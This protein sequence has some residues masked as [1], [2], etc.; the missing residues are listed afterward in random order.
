LPKLIKPDFILTSPKSEDDFER[1]Y[2]FRWEQ[3]RKPLNLPLGSERDPLDERSFNCMALNCENL[4]IGVGSIQSADNNT[5]RIRYMAVM[6]QLRG[7]GI[8]SEIVK[9]LLAYAV[10]N[11]ACKCWLNARSNATQFYKK[12]GFE[13][14]GEIETELTVPHFKMEI[15][16]IG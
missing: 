7:L 5:M 2:E 13:V 4:I 8:G 12:Q 9:S 6:Q 11:R 10:E 14:I 1:Y 15:S 16:L 3:L